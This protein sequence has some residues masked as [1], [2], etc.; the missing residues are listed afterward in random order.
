MRAESFLAGIAL[1][2]AIVEAFTALAL[3]R[4]LPQLGLRISPNGL[5]STTIQFGMAVGALALLVL[6]GFP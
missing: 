6:F 5:T 2:L 3:R 1:L 4:A